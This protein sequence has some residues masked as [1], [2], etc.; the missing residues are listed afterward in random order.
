MAKRKQVRRYVADI[1]RR[2]AHVLTNAHKAG[3]MERHVNDTARA[4]ALAGHAVHVLA[5]DVRH[6]YF[7]TA[8]GVNYWPLPAL[9]LLKDQWNS[10]G[11]QL[12]AGFAE[13]KNYL[14]DE[15]LT[16]KRL[17]GPD[18]WHTHN[19]ERRDAVLLRLLLAIDP[20]AG[21]VNTCH[22][23]RKSA[24]DAIRAVDVLPLVNLL[25]GPSAESVVSDA[26]LS[27]LRTLSVDLEKFRPPSNSRDGD[28]RIL[29]LRRPVMLDPAASIQ[30]RKD[31][32]LS[33]DTFDALKPVDPDLKLIICT[34]E[35]PGE[36]WHNNSPY[37]A[38][39]LG[40]IERSPYAEDIDFLQCTPDQMP[41]AYRAVSLSG[42]FAFRGSTEEPFGLV[43]LEAMASAVP[44]IATDVG[45]QRT[46]IGRAGDLVD[47]PA[48]ETGRRNEIWQTLA[49]R[50]H[51]VRTNPHVR[52]MRIQDGL[53]QAAQWSTPMAMRQLDVAYQRAE[54]MVDMGSRP[55]RLALSRNSDAA[56]SLV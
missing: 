45:G 15:L 40:R 18:I 19:G 12:S 14:R 47:R 27:R 50:A 30:P 51:Q 11:Q 35:R 23:D 42:G 46:A 22:S 41:G 29:S 8:T 53:R 3:G 31:Q 17:I 55:A 4:Q 21:K 7:D 20:H 24:W 54:Q 43:L 56:T 5:S 1:K 49:L 36:R 37:L 2:I 28:S 32:I 26:R 25:V 48:V 52:E 38:Q 33:V 10:N 34:A 9:G 16:L 39:L 44:V 6:A 13:A